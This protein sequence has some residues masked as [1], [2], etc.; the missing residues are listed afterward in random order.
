MPRIH[1]TVVVIIAIA[2]SLATWWATRPAIVDPPP[3][4]AL[5]VSLPDEHDFI[6]ATISPDGRRLV[7]AAT[8]DGQARL[9]LRSLDRFGID[10]IAGTEDATQPFFAPDGQRVGFFSSGFL[11]WVALDGS[12]PV[13]VTP[14]VG[15]TAGASWGANDEIIFAPLGGRGLRRVAATGLGNGLPPEVSQITELDEDAGEVSHGWPH[16]LPDGRSVLFTVGRN[17]RDPRLAWFS[18]ESHERELLD[19]ADGAAF[20]VD[21]GHFVY[22][23]R[24]EIFAVPVDATEQTVTGPSRLVASGVSGSAVGY[25][26]LG[27]SAM[28]ASLNGLLLYAPDSVGSSDNLLTW[29]DREGSGTAIDGV[30]ARHQAPRVSPDGSRIVMAIYSGTFSRDLW[31]LDAVTRQRRPLTEEAGDNHSPLW[32]ADSQRITFASNR[33]GPQ[34]IYRATTREPATVE[35]LLFGDGRTP[36][37]WSPGERSLFFHELQPKIGRDIWVWTQGTGESTMLLGSNANERSPAIS[38]NGRWLAYVSDAEDGDQVFVRPSSE[39]VDRRISP[40]GGAEPV[41]SADATELFYRNGRD[42]F[43]VAVNADTGDVSPPRRLFAGT[44]VTDP[45]GNVPAYDVSPDGSRFLMLRP[46]ARTGSLLVVDHWQRTV[47]A[48]NTATR[49]P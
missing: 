3:L 31:T 19:S 37:S 29:V 22:A 30:A 7:Y 28:V 5:S 27:R 45:G 16:I 13:D 12:Q 23:R 32:S 8:A 41:W 2:S 4:R 25:T 18:L 11:R 24:G 43:S 34:R 40:S 46:V 26:R 47:F 33:D 20:H 10:P 14:V 9:F 48:D 42:L 44:F 38:P 6:E 49:E 1:P 15:T 39:A 17:E 21:S 36:G 35:T